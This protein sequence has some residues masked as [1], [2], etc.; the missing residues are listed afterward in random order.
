MNLEQKINFLKR[1]NILRERCSA[2]KVDGFL[3]SDFPDVRYLTG[4]PAEGC[5]VLVSKSGDSIFAPL[6]LGDQAKMLLQNDTNLNCICSRYLLVELKKLVK[7]WC[8][9]K[10]GYDSTKVSV[11]LLKK[12][13]GFRQVRWVPLDEFVLS[14]R[15]IKDKVEI[16]YISQACRRTLE[17]SKI[18]IEKLKEGQSEREI[19]FS[20]NQLF[21]K[22]GSDGPAFDTIV[23]FGKNSV[24][25]H[26]I[27]TGKKLVKNSVVVMD[28]GC[29]VNGYRSDL[30]RTLFFGIMPLRFRKV[31]GIVKKAQQEGIAL[32]HSGISAKRVDFACREVIRKAGYENYFVHGTGHG[33]G[34]ETHEPPRL[35][36]KSKHILKEGMVVTIE[37]GIYLPGEFGVRIEDTVLVTKG[38]YKVLTR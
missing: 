33:I 5:F 38:G 29:I 31:Y 23:A 19:A 27:I 2:K 8:L 26:H 6:L 13:A 11:S 28:L 34:L 3:T 7:K 32:I 22:M 37:P 15:M 25:P 10:I 17:S 18:L 30:T 35:G 16:D 9:K 21:H 24:F 4:F 1:R 14:Q 36:L 12:L 20:A